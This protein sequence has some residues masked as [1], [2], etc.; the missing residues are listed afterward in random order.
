MVEKGIR[1]RIFQVINIIN[2][3]YTN[4]KYIKSYDKNI[5]SLYLVYLEMQIICMDGQCLKNFL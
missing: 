5:E 2:K 3:K 4:N 1:G